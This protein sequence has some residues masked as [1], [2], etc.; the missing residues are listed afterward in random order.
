[1]RKYNKLAE[2]TK[3]KI[4]AKLKERWE[5]NYDEMVVLSDLNFFSLCEH[6]MLPFIGK[7]AV[8]YLPNGKVV[9]VSKLARLVECFSRRL[10]IQ[11]RLTQQ[12]ANS[13]NEN[14]K[15][16]GVGVVLQATHLCMS[17]R[18]IKNGATM[19]TSCLLGAFIDKPE[20]RA[21]FLRLATFGDSQKI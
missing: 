12:I 8:A 19:R 6:H 9:G 5:E 10:Q 21:E 4:G 3:R 15:P 11:E 2:E 17:L 20:C 16:I 7:A 1:M 14:F 18:G 13:L